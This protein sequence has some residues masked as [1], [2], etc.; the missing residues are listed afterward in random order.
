MNT[1]LIGLTRIPFFLPLAA[2]TLMLGVAMSF[3][4]PYLSLF[5]VEQADMTP[6]QLGAFMTAI[7]ASGVVASAF[8][9]KWS[10]RHG[11]HRELLL[12]ALIASALG[13]LLLCLVRNYGAL[14]GIGIA[15]LGTGGSAMS[16]VFSFARGA[17]RR[18]HHRT[19]APSRSRRCARCCRWLGSSARPSA[20]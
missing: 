20:R 16:L 11:H 19:N 1:R 17:A 14:L 12:G 2:A 13:F 5:S 8:A 4:A 15:F 7:A 9:D 10:D 6:L 18:R 3:T